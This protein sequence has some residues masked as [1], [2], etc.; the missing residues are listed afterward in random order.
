[1]DYVRNFKE[2]EERDVTSR[3]EEDSQASNV[4]IPLREGILKTNFGLPLMV[5][6]TKVMF[7]LNSS[8]T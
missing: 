4:Q 6:V 8:Q 3:V 1:M 2:Y 7:H 5:L